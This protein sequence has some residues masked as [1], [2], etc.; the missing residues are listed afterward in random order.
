MSSLS[1]EQQ[2][3]AP[4][5]SPGPTPAPARTV[6]PDGRSTRWQQHRSER[7]AE[8]VHAARR[9][10]HRHGPDV[11]MDVVAQT[12]GTS[13]SIV[14]RYFVDK[15]GLQAAVGAVVVGQMHAALDAASRSGETPREGLR[16]MIAEYLAMVEA[17]PNV[18]WFV[19]RPVSEDASAPLGHFLDAVARL[20]ARP[21][22]RVLSGRDEAVSG[23]GSAAAPVPG[24]GS[25]FASDAVP[26]SGDLLADLWGTGA[27]GF[28]RGAGEW[29]LAHRDDADA[30]SLDELTERVTA[31]LWTGPV[32]ALARS[33]GAEPPS[34]PTP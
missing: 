4:A 15:P 10:V 17:S 20:V 13:K 19:T 28:V 25:G 24:S 18:Y 14:Y 33:R 16:A 11:S 1:A 9:A 12:A 22:A 6:A 30:P 31:W 27:V 32:S 3:G 7:R 21:F 26:G 34:T 2:A 29:W 23:A 5:P 8:L